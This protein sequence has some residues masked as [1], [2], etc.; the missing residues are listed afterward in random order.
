MPKPT[1]PKDF[2]WGTATAS[3]QVEGAAWEDGRGPCIW[4]TFARTPGKV[5]HGHNGDIGPDQYHRYKEDVQLMKRLG[6]GAYR[7][8]LAWPRVFPQGYGEQNPKGFDYY[9]RLIDELLDNGIAPAI[10]LYHWDLPQRLEDKG[11]WPV[12]DTALRFADYAKVCFDELGDKVNMW[13]TLNEPHCSSIGGYGQGWHAPGRQ[14]L[15]D[16]YNAIHHLNLG[17][18]LAVQAFRQGGLDGV[19]GTTLDL[20]TWRP[21]TDRPEDVEAADRAKDRKTRMFM[22]PLVGRAYPQRHLDAYG[23]TMPVEDGDAEVMATPV[24]FVGVNMY[25]EYP[26][27]WDESQPEKW[28]EA[29]H[30][31][32]ESAMGWPIVPAG[33]RRLLT[34]ITE[35]YGPLPLY[36]TENGCAADDHLSEDGTRCHDRDRIDYLRGHLSACRDAI[37]AGVDLRGYFL[38]SFIDNFEWAF[39]YTKRFGI[40]YCDYVDQRRVP[41]DSFYFYRD[42]I[43]GYGDF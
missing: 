2:L 31:Q 42:V 19:I 27:A 11:G 28:R 17:H 10:T 14:E 8:S 7:F 20:G 18:G 33:L 32:K 40:V 36:V 39:G 6:I 21:A 37:D 23:L 15:Q 38:W 4:D 22:N 16:G 12:R 25:H 30:W 1:F 26:V 9:H 29:P 41:K 24:D 35:E 13:I 34:D 3:Y 5:Q 43:A